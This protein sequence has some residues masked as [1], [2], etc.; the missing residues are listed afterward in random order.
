MLVLAPTVG[1]VTHEGVVYAQ[2]TGD[3]PHRDWG[4]VLL[5]ELLTFE[6]VFAHQ[7]SLRP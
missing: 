2:A 3:L 1:T 7:G 4:N 5:P 6:F